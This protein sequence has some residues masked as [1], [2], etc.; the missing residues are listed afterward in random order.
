[1]AGM[2]K[3]AVVLFIL[4]ICSCA[5]RIER[6]QAEYSWLSRVFSGQPVNAT[7]TTTSNPV[8]IPPPT[9]TVIIP[10]SITY[11][12]SQYVFPAN[13]AITALTPTITGTLASCAVT[14]ALPVGLAFDTTTCSI[15]GTPT[16]TAGP[17]TYTISAT[18]TTGS[19]TANISIRISGT[20]AFRVFGQLGNLTTGT[21]NNGGISASS[22]AQ[23]SNLKADSFGNLVISDYN[24]RRILY[25]TASNIAL[26]GNITATKVY[27]QFGD[28]TCVANF[29]IGG[30]TPGTANASNMGA[31][32]SVT[33][34]DSGNVY[35]DGGSRVL[36]F[37]SDANLPATRV[38]GQLTST[39]FACTAVN[40]NGSC[41]AGSAGPNTLSNVQQMIVDK[42][43][44]I[45]ISDTSNNRVLYYPSGSTT[46]TRVYGQFGSFTCAI[47][48]NNGSCSGSAISANSLSAPTGVAIDS[49]GNLYITDGGNQRILYY[50]AGTTT[51]TLVYG[52]SGN[53]TTAA[54]GT[55][56]T[57]FNGVW[58]IALDPWDNLYAADYNNR[59][60]LYFPKGS[61]TATRVYG[62]LGNFTTSTIN[63][64]GLTTGLNNAQSVSVDGFGNV[65]IADTGNNRVV[66]Y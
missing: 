46:P 19:A 57:A 54:I 10:F 49:V 58:M 4:L 52:Q 62:Q 61:T 18:G 44:G 17:T 33:M 31:P 39:N 65:F 20:T 35:A 48:N 26:G 2:G 12:L 21:L 34:D 40:N 3:I 37:S 43:D 8:S 11:T 9:T 5:P 50:P 13:T 23:P 29:N 28:F 36:F 27:G 63:N 1:M 56:A 22:L 42:S 59:R 41:A 30:C 14:P 66:M 15:T 38:Y 6:S 64:G 16:T 51:A 53:F 55:S 25:Y 45:Y 24:N 32:Q 7:A 60:V 47:A